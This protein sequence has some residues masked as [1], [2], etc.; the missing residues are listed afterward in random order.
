M[1]LNEFDD[2]WDSF[3]RA[4]EENVDEK[5][6]VNL[7]NFL[8]DLC[9]NMKKKTGIEFTYEDGIIVVGCLRELLKLDLRKHLY[10]QPINKLRNLIS[11]E[12]KNLNKLK[13][14]K[15]DILELALENKSSRSAI[16][17]LEEKLEIQRYLLRKAQYYFANPNPV[18]GKAGPSANLVG[19]M[20]WTIIVAR[21]ELR[22][23]YAGPKSMK[24]ESLMRELVAVV[25]KTMK[26]SGIAKYVSLPTTASLTAN[27][28]K[29]Y[30]HQYGDYE[31]GRFV[32]S[33]ISTICP[34]AENTVC[35]NFCECY[36]KNLFR[37]Y[38]ELRTRRT[39]NPKRK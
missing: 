34:C 1:G 13:E 7:Q 6:I 12:E 2:A 32:F 35:L 15:G 25:S 14:K 27:V 18:S 17:I 23:Y 20:L 3:R 38:F 11:K 33:D 24:I 16:T 21:V 9:E 26:A 37:C 36:N 30:S 19:D 4:I 22:N 10:R 28:E 5:I 29:F 39:K 8:T 31:M